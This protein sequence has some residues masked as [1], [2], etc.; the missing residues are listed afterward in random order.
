MKKTILLA[1]V[2]LA[3]ASSRPGLALAQNVFR[4]TQSA[5]L[6][7]A[8]M[9]NAGNWLFEVSHRSDTP[10]SRGSDALWGVDG[11]PDRA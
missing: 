6:P 3:V 7:T 1:C 10:I 8:A 2:V 4:S 9:L 5:N 11:P